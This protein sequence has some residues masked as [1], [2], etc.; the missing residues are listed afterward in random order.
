MNA[1]SCFQS[2]YNK[3]EQIKF[4]CISA[5]LIVDVLLLMCLLF[6][7]IMFKISGFFPGLRSCVSFSLFPD[8]HKQP[9]NQKPEALRRID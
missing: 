2:S 4:Q 8:F 7:E 9:G 5:L 6:S 1:L 3:S